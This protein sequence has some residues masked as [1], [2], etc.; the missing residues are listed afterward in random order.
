MYDLHLTPEQLE[1]RDTVRDFV[2]NEVKPVVLDPDRLQA[3]DWTLPAGVLEKA[4][5]LGLRALTLPEDAGGAGADAL[6]ACIVCEELAAGD[7]HVAAVLAETA[8]LAGA[9]FG[10]CASPAQRARYLTRFLEDDGFHLAFAGPDPDSELGWGYHRPEPVEPAAGLRLARHAGGDW[11]ADGTARYVA[12]APLAKL[13]IVAA[14]EDGAPGGPAVF[15]VPRESAGITVRDHRDAGAGHDVP[16]VPWYHGVRGEVAFRGCRVPADDRLDRDGAARLMAALRVSGRGAPQFEAVNLGVGRAA[17]DAAIAYAG[18]RVQGGRPI[19]E[20]QAIGTI[21]A[22]AAVRLTVARGIV[23]QAAWAADHP[24]AYADR[25]LPDLPLQTIARVYCAGAVA[26]ATELAAECFGA[27][28]VMRDMPLHKYLHDARVFVQSGASVS[29]ARF[30]I[31]E[32]LAGYER[33]AA[34]PAPAA[35]AGATG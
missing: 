9:L 20:H 12:N 17:L 19:V 34:S 35:R 29:V 24:D 16:P 5:R 14:A 33:P 27:M 25:S 32:A 2:E 31:A 10:G 23:W 3:L 6:T 22:E 13:L 15:L 11:V 1:I 8:R 7:A 21:L 26:E 18:I 30:R 28:G 4:S